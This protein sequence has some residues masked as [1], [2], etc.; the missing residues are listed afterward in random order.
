MTT[1]PPGSL[2]A[3]DLLDVRLSAAIGEGGCAIC[4][5]RDRAETTMLESILGERVLDRGFRAD[6]E[7][8]YGFCRD[9][10][11]ELLVVDRRGS[12]ILGSSILYGAMLER[13]VA[14]IRE[15]LATRGGRRRRARLGEVGRRPPCVVCREGATAAEVALGR[16]A[17]R[18]TDPAWSTAASAIPFCLDDLVRFLAA[19]AD[20]PAATPV[21]DAQLARLDD[22]RARLEGFAHHSAQDRRHLMTDAERS[23]ADE[24]AHVL[25]DA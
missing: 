10:A 12:G 4:V 22:L 18:V 11:R 6:L 23:A 13:R 14:A 2:P 17:E 19:A 20:Q 9:H 21:I 5:V 3:R 7:R 25:G 8:E 1:P 16:L 15:A 24:A